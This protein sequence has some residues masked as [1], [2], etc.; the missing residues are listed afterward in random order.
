M[1][2]SQQHLADERSALLMAGAQV[3]G[4]IKD[5]KL[6]LDAQRTDTYTHILPHHKFS[7]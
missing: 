4:S 3:S 1:A 7:L 6:S 5:L 2:L